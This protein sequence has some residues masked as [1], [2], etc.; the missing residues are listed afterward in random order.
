MKYLSNLNKY[1]GHYKGKGINHEKQSFTGLL[2]IT[3]VLDKRGFEINFNAVGK[4]GSIYHKEKSIIAPAIDE[5]LCLWNLNTN[6]PG[7][8][9][10]SL[11]SAEPRNGSLITFVFGFNDVDNINAFREE[12]ALDLWGNGDITYTYSWGL[13][14][15]EFQERSGVR[16]SSILKIIDRPEMIKHYTE[17]QEPDNSHYHGGD[18][19][20]SIG[21]PLG[22][23]LGLKK[24]GI[25]HELLKPGRRTSWPHA[26]SAEEEFVFVIEGT[27]D[28]W[29]DGHLYPLQPGDAVAFPV[30]TGISHTVINSSSE[31]VRLLVVGE[32][33]KSENKVFYPL[34]PTRNELIK[35]KGTFWKN[36]PSNSL[37]S[38]DG[39]PNVLR[40]K[41]N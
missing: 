24:L 28:V 39:L 29:I 15:G 33:S 21:S 31:D 38:H 25:H 8:I 7:L 40:E 10:H 30:P 19:L 1:I 41:K 11:K 13:P 37:G 35:Q 22:K 23:T 12:I 16:M 2:S 6:T 27:P 34:H 14:G 5:K 4:D 9:P 17:L 20:L 36:H 26:E 18:E 32:V 3:S